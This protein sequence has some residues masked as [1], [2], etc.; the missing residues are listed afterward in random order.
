LGGGRG[1]FVGG[2]AWH[3]CSCVRLPPLEACSAYLHARAT[4]SATGQLPPHPSLPL[5]PAP[6]PAVEGV[7]YVVDTGVVKQ[8]SY[9]PSTGMDALEVVA[10]SRVQATQ[11]AGRAGR[12]RPGKVGP[13]APALGRCTRVAVPPPPP[14]SA[15]AA[16]GPLFPAAAAPP[17]GP[18]RQARGCSGGAPDARRPAQPHA[19]TSRSRRPGSCR[20]PAARLG[21]AR[22]CQALHLPRGPRRPS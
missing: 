20:L 1:G 19:A 21:A 8:K 5:T 15:L 18:P 14:G 10:I 17:C 3:V 11:R 6:V 4:S 9:N 7:V 12:T 16:A 22:H 2:L 13:P